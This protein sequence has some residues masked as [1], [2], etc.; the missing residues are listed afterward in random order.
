[1]FVNMSDRKYHIAV[2]LFFFSLLFVL[3]YPSQNGILYVNDMMLNMYEFEY[4]GWSGLLHSYNMIFL[5]YVPSF[6]Y[7]LLY[8]LFGLNWLGWHIVL[9]LMHAG[10]ALLLMIFL[11]KVLVEQRRILLMLAGLFFL[12]SPYQ[13]EVVAWGALFHYS[14]SV[15]FLLLCLLSQI[16]YFETDKRRYILSFHLSYLCALFC[17]E[18]AFVFPVVFV[19][20]AI[21]VIPF[22]REI[23]R[24][25]SVLRTLKYFISGNMLCLMLYFIM[26]KLVYGNWIAHYGAEAHAEL[27]WRHMYENLLN[28]HWKFLLYY[29]YLPEQVRHFYT[30]SGIAPYLLLILFAVVGLFVVYL[31]ASGKYLRRQVSL[32][33]F[34]YFSFLAMLLPVLNL[35]QSFTF[36]VQSDRY[37]YSASLFFYAFLVFF[38]N[39]ISNRKVLLGISAVLLVFNI[40]CLREI[41]SLWHKS[42]DLSYALMQS[43]PLEPHQKALLLNLPDNY[44]GV[45][46]MRNGFNE[47][48]SLIHE[49]D[50]KN[51]NRPVAWVNVFS[52]DNE[53]SVEKLNDSTYYVK[54]IRDGKWYY[55][56][57]AGATD[58]EKDDYRVDF[59]EWNTAYLLTIRKQPSDTTY[60]MHCYGNRW[61]IADTIF[62]TAKYR[63]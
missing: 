12:L 7:I 45:Y 60:L 8:K 17:F 27:P 16:S 24:K 10:N 37:G 25:Q 14:L 63:Q 26:N 29:R 43:Y 22:L 39:H 62:P 18:Q 6:F 28:Y 48:L 41:V 2:F 9:C 3:Y 51:V 31:V 56:F 4:T 19:L 50:Y 36:E 52:D 55:Y 44:A 49:K 1:M 38:L 20:N 33:L 47:G 34:L 58:Y 13:T 32:V 15:T 11:R 46:T 5:W 35:D 30:H 54:C 40:F 57:G 23:S 59:D 21:F 61:R 53:T 42:G